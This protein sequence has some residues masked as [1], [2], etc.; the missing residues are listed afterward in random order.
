MTTENVD[1]NVEIVEQNDVNSADVELQEL[2]TKLEKQTQLVEKLR[3][4]E[5]HNQNIAKEVGA[6]NLEDALRAIQSGYGKEVDEWKTKFETLNSEYSNL[7][8]NIKSTELDRVLNEVLRNSKVKDVNTTLKVIDKTKIQW[9]E[10]G[11]VDATSLE[12][13]VNELKQTDPILFEDVQIPDVKTAGQ[14]TPISGFEKEI[15]ACKTQ[16]EIEAVLKKFNR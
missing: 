8:E 3:Q 1:T 11:K 2:K 10:D 4:Q 13:I 9:T 12:V 6:K 7:K 16:K 5:K 15:T 14:G